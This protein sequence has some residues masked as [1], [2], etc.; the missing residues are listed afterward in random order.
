M[1]R[2]LTVLL[3]TVLLVMTSCKRE[4]PRPNPWGTTT[5]PADNDSVTAPLL[6][7]ILANG[8][9]IVVTI[10]GPETYYE[11]HGRCLGVHYLLCE[12]FCKMLGV[13]LRVDVCRDTVD[14]LSRVVAGEAD[15]VAMPMDAA[16]DGLQACFSTATEGQWHWLVNSHN[17]ALASRLDSWLTAEII[18][19]TQQEQDY[20]LSPKSITRTDY[21]V[22]KNR[23]KGIISSYDYLFQRYAPVARW[24]WRLL[25]AQ[26]YQ[27]S[28]FDP[29]AHSW[30]GACGLM[31][32]MPT[33]ADHLQLRRSD[34]YDP[35]AN[36][37]AAARYIAELTQLFSDI[38]SPIERTKFV[39]A[40]YN[41]GQHH[42][43]DAMALAKKYG[44][45][46]HLWSSVRK[47]V[48][49]LATPEYY[50]DPTVKYG[51][52]RG[53]ETANY[54]DKII[55]RW[56]YY[57]GVKTTISNTAPATPSSPTP[58]PSTPPPTKAKKK[59]YD[60]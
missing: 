41:G 34:I 42:I 15:I 16:V 22:M 35:E 56:D 46:S 52:M 23:D 36:V 24:D 50:N 47:Y 37:A 30:A 9:L 28:T 27:E 53:S 2:W 59:K 20:Y 58:P 54:V 55:D 39:L 14:M 11:Y 7:D 32:I 1:M 25:A 3:L 26:C 29:R 31:Q 48:L 43:R 33:T 21:S 12:K 4:V 17:S 60:I 6:D 49:R 8:E 13:S 18:A 19:K 45:N 57:R 10:S 38:D 40:A 5:V 44:D 51:Y